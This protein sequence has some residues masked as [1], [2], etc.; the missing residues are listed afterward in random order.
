MA[1]H[2]APEG[3]KATQVLTLDNSGSEKVPVQIEA[4]TREVSV[5]GVEK[6]AKTDS[7]IIYPEQ[8]VLL[9]N[10][11]RNIRVTWNSTEKVTSEKAFR[12]IASQ[13]PLEF[14]EENSKN[15][16]NGASL[17]FLV[18]YVASAYVTPANAESKVKVVAAKVVKP[19][20]V[21]IEMMNSGT[22]HKLLRPKK[23]QILS[24]GKVL[25]EM[26]QVKDLESENILAG[27]TR[28]FVVNLPKEISA[29]NIDVKLE[30][31]DA[32]D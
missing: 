30:L 31:E 23:L 10:E 3:S 13:L 27:A 15:Q 25:L 20:V 6:R 22:A 1:I 24:E 7:F 9:P 21:E 5:D 29:K 32:T 11:K 8:V 19:K 26:A 14:H 4:V 16:K 2:F 18:Q 17:K 12:I 28:K